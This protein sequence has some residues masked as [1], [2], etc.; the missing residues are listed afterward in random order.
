M[1]GQPT[2]SDPEGGEL[3]D[4]FDSPT[5]SL[6]SLLSEICDDPAFTLS[7][8]DA[9]VASPATSPSPSPPPPAS[10]GLEETDSGILQDQG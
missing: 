3:L 10:D 9:T 7:V 6:D 5:G 8:P 2:C 1:P 4:A